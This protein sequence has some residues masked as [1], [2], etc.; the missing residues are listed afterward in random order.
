MSDKMYRVVL[1]GRPNVGKSTFFNLLTGTRRAVVQDRPGVTRDIQAGEAEWC[2]FTFEVMDTGG[3]IEGLDIWSSEVKK[4]A[5]DCAKTADVLLFVLDGK[6]GLHPEDKE[7]VQF[8]R[9]LKKPVLGVVNKI[10]IREDIPE[11]IAEFYELGLDHMIGASFEHRNSIDDILDWIIAP[12]REKRGEVKPKEESDEEFFNR[13]ENGGSGEIQEEIAERDRKGDLDAPL[14]MAVVGKPNAGKSSL[15]N[16]LLGEE[17][18]IVSPIAGTTVDSVSVTFKFEG[19]EYNF[20][21]TAG[22]RRRAKREDDVERISAYKSEDAVEHAQMVLVVID[23]VEGPTVQD[24]RIVELCLSKNKAV[25]L[26]MNKTDIAEGKHKEFRKWAR[27]RVE[28]YFH[29]FK[30]IPV[31]FVSAKTGRG[32]HDLFKTIDDVWTRLRTQISTKDC[33]DFLSRVIRMAPA[34]HYR[35]QDIKFYYM[36]QT[37]QIPPSFIMFVNEP[38][39]LTD[40]YRRYVT[41]QIK[42]QFDLKGVP[43][44]IY[45]KKRVRRSRPN[46]GIK[47]DD[48][49][50]PGFRAPEVTGEDDIDYTQYMNDEEE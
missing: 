13:I 29:F 15:V 4:R 26:V 37:K 18:L 32:L 49:L 46:V 31:A 45:F 28:Q 24:A 33:N 48:I 17:R 14:K 41:N 35:T 47:D 23:A 36:T 39:G 11:K 42:E 5:K 8:F 1:I 44:R 19:R 12:L 50:I 16:K 34:P 30:D 20:I 9:E 38:D 7:L 22:L 27:D 6:Y 40:S 10:D 21:D 43:I 3:I 25:I 2:G